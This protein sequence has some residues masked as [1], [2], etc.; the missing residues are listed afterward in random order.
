MSLKLRTRATIIIAVSFTALLTAFLILT[1]Y[2]VKHSFEERTVEEMRSQLHEILTPLNDSSTREDINRLFERYGRTGESQLAI[3]IWKDGE[4]L[5]GFGPDS[6]Q[7]HIPVSLPSITNDTTFGVDEHFVLYATRKGQFLGASVMSEH[8]TD[9]VI[10]EMIQ[11]FDVVLLIG[12]VL[13]VVVAYTLSRVALDPVSKLTESTE[14]LL[15]SGQ[16][17]SRLPIPKSPQEAVTLAALFN[18]VLEER[19]KSI[20]TLKTFTADVAHELRTPLTILRG[21]LEVELR[22]RPHEP[23]ERETLES[24]LEEVKHLSLIVDDLLYLA[25]IENAAEGTMPDKTEV[26]LADTV[27]RVVERLQPLIEKKHLRMLC[28]VGENLSIYA[29]GSYIDRLIYNLVLNAI[30]FTPENGT[31]SITSSDRQGQKR[32]LIRDTGIGM[33]AEALQHITERFYRADA[34]RNRNQGNVGLGLAIANSITRRYGIEMYLDS[35]LGKGTTV[36]L[37]LPQP[38]QI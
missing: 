16:L 17:S 36:S 34:T 14:Q 6:M 30:Q 4:H 22:S 25:R 32:L 15:G 5:G 13:S 7:S 28:E 24:C 37:L 19:D 3:A 2:T 9:E 35:E 18:R 21:E 20:H 26:S 33:S 29:S 10:E 8:I 27:N 23:S 38:T 12:L 11:I 31:I 1:F